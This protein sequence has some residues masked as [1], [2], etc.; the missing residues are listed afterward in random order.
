MNVVGSK[1]I[2]RIKQ[3]SDGS[4]DR[5]NARLV[6]KG[7]TQEHGVDF[8]ETFSPVI[9]HATI[10]L[11]LIHAIAQNWKVRQLDVKNVFLNGTLNED[12]Y[13]SQPPGLKNQHFPNYVC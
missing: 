7:Y 2:F 8:A 4:L 1:W 11:V 10:R 6:A 5:Y 12:V 3:K 13:M 9:K